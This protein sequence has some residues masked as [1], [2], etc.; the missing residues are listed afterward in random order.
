M[1]FLT[2]LDPAGTSAPDMVFR[3]LREAIATGD[4]SPGV[5]LPS[6]AEL[7]RGFGVAVMTVRVAL[8]VARDMGLLTTIRGRHGGNF[9][10]TDVTERMAEVAR[11]KKLDPRLMRELT[12]WR[13]AI[14]GEAC[15]LAAERGKAEDFA[16]IRD[17]AAAFDD[18]LPEF[19]AP[20]FADARLHLLIAEISGSSRLLAQ[21]KDIQTEMTD[22][23]LSVA[24]HLYSKD[25]TN[26][27]HAR[28]VAAICARKGEA[29]RK[30]MVRHA[31]ETCAW[32]SALL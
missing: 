29:A 28:I 31:E 5:R 4:L 1:E 30:A 6:E 17:A 8:A 2:P 23:I 18:M 14:S 26:A 9:V 19:P 11:R 13:R 10:A 15:L 7:A 32:V 16:R 24:G 12:D 22:V 25:Y 20:R 21:E 27:S 3:R